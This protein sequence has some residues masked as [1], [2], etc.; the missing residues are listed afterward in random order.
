MSLNNCFIKVARE[1]CTVGDEHPNEH[2]AGKGSFWMLDDSANDMFEQ[3]NYRRRRTRR[4]RHAKMLLGGQFQVIFYIFWRRNVQN[5]IFQGPSYPELLYQA[6]SRLDASQYCFLNLSKNQ[7]HAQISNNHENSESEEEV[8]VDDSQ[9]ELPGISPPG[10][11]LN[12]LNGYNTMNNFTT[13]TTLT[14]EEGHSSWDILFRN[15]VIQHMTQNSEQVSKFSK[16]TIENL[17]KK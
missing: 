12:Q 16:F 9:S 7:E 3:G 2:G 15:Q 8:Q 17:I 5:R 13:S 4:Q 11:A 10:N 6:R 14:K 1:K